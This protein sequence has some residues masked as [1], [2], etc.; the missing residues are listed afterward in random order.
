MRLDDGTR[1]A[2]CF[3]SVIEADSLSCRRP[4]ALAGLKL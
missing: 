3:E 2:R 1:G 4:R